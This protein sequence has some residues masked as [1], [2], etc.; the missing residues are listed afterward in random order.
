MPIAYLTQYLWREECVSNQQFRRRSTKYPKRKRAW[1]EKHLR[2]AERKT[3]RRIAVSRRVAG[4]RRGHGQPRGHLADGGHDDVDQQADDGVRDEQ[5]AGAGLRERLS[6]ADDETGADGAADGNHTH[7]ARLEAAMERGLGAR[8]HARDVDIF[9]DL[10]LLAI[11]VA[12]PRG[13]DPPVDEISRHDELSLRM[14]CGRFESAIGNFKW[15]EMR[16]E[17][18]VYKRGCE[19][20]LKSHNVT[21]GMG[22]EWILLSPADDCEFAALR[23][24]AYLLI[25]QKDH[26]KHRDGR[27]AGYPARKRSMEDV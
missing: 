23:C 21:S 7:V 14:R 15:D 19:N 18:K 26:N 4:K 6:R 3:K 17:R 12:I 10:N 2:P 24:F 13:R 11:M 1:R 27:S 5:G 9:V 20:R 8:L 25:F 22:T 16:D